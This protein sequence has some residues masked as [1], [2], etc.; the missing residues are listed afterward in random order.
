MWNIRNFI[1]SDGRLDR[2]TRAGE[3][4]NDVAKKK[5]AECP[6]SLSPWYKCQRTNL[7]RL[8]NCRFDNPAGHVREPFVAAVVQVRQLLVIE[9][10]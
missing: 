9:T 1:I 3:K 10:E 6:A 7:I 8:S 2:P 4:A 5:S